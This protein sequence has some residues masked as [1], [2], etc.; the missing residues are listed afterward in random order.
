MVSGESVSN[1]HGAEVLEHWSA[2]KVPPVVLLY[3]AALSAVCIAVAYFVFDSGDAVK[4]LVVAAVGAIGAATP[5]V[6]EK[7]EY[8]LTGSG[9][10]KRK[11]NPKKPGEFESVFQWD[12]LSHIAPTKRGF[13]YYKVVNETRPV[14]RF[15]KR[16]LSDTYSGEVHVEKH[17]LDRV[18]GLVERQRSATPA[19]V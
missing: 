5:G 17:D 19:A 3:L 18:L 4:G 15:W 1:G 7:V 10:E 11:S 13:K 2:R 8:Q 6:L 9:I 16:H 14:V 12:Q